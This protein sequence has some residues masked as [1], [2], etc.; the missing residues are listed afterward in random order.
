MT[1]AVQKVLQEVEQLSVEERLELHR[2]LVERIPMSDDLTDEDF[3]VLAAESF[4]RLDEEE[5]EGAEA[6]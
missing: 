3:A 4:R 1:A 5:A 6:G 2:H